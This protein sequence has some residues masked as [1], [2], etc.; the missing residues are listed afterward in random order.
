M[1]EVYIIYKDLEQSIERSKK[2]RNQLSEYA[3]DVKKRVV[4]A[5][6]VLPGSDRAGY[7]STAS[8][9]AE[10][11]I[12]DMVVKSNR[13]AAYENS[14]ASFISTAKSKDKYV[15]NQMET[16]A[17]S[18]LPKRTWYQQAGDFLYNTFCVDLVNNWSWTRYI[19]DMNKKDL[20][21]LKHVKEIVMD[22]FK[23]G[24]GKY[25][26]NLVASVATI[27]ASVAVTVA[28]IAA[29]PF[30]GGAST[31]A[32][33]VAWSAFGAA[34]CSTVST[35]I[36]CVNMSSKIAANSKAL[37]LSGN[38]FKDD[39]G[40]VGAARYYGNI[41]SK[42]EEWARTD[43]GDEETNKDYAFY[44]NMIDTT[45]VIA[46]VG[47]V[48]C[49]I[50]ASAG[51][52]R[53]FR[54]TKNVHKQVKGYEYSIDNVIHN[55]KG[56]NGIYI[57][58]PGLQVRDPAKLYNGYEKVKGTVDFIKKKGSETKTIWT[59]ETSSRITG[60]S[61]VEGTI[62]STYK[63]FGKIEDINKTNEKLDKDLKKLLETKK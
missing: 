47:Q 20:T 22:W 3:T 23:Y 37:S 43:M 8:N 14:V 25:V 53:D 38:V 57:T 63:N 45:K 49:N 35:V 54:Y 31:A 6:D 30:T 33:V 39:D 60:S 27:V 15:S 4:D 16:I 1:S 46:D 9:L 44:G 34:V 28:A 55:F 58:R 51:M 59:T 7:A 56:Q 29:I 10:A 18:V 13:F 11:K 19:S 40:D 61:D 5:V 52:V 50:T 41:S 42:S 21:D 12:K 26:L 24:D 17:G 36:T 32:L 2:V 62:K 48:V